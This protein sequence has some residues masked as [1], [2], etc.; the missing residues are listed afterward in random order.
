MGAQI[1]NPPQSAKGQDATDDTARNYKQE[2]GVRIPQNLDDAGDNLLALFG[3][4]C[5]G[6]IGITGVSFFG[7][8]IS[9]HQ[10][11]SCADGKGKTRGSQHSM[12]P[13]KSNN[14]ESQ[15]SPGEYRTDNPKKQGNS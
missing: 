11:D 15:R 12:A 3:A 4:R 14:S 1:G 13:A 8:M 10:P 7:G 9:D 6:G 2:P 5:R